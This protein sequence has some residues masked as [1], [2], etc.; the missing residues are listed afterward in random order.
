MG[1]AV[2]PPPAVET[3]TGLSLPCRGSSFQSGDYVHVSWSTTY[4]H[5]S[6]THFSPRRFSQMKRKGFTLIELLVVIAIIGLLVALLL[7][8]LARARES[9][10]SATCQSNLRSFGQGFQLFAERD[11]GKR[12]CSGATISSAMAVPTRLAGSPICRRSAAADGNKMLCPSNELRGLEKL[13]DMIGSATPSS[14]DPGDFVATN[15]TR[16]PYY[17]NS[18]YCNNLV[19]ASKTKTI[20]DNNGSGLTAGTAARI[21]VVSKMVADGFNTNYAQSWFMARSGPK[22][23]TTVPSS[24]LPFTGVRAGQKDQGGAYAG[25]ALR[26]IEK[27]KVVS[28]AIPMLGDA[29]PGDTNEAVLVAAINEEFPAGARLA[30]SFNDGPSFVT[31][32]IN[33]NTLDKI[34]LGTSATNTLSYVLE[35]DVLPLPDEEGLGGVDIN[36]DGINDD[37]VQGGLHGGL[38]G[39]VILQDI[40]DFGTVHGSGSN[41]SCNILFADGSVKTIYDVNGDTFINPGFPMTG[42]TAESDG[43][44]NSRC[45]IGPADMYNGPALNLDEIKKNQFE[46]S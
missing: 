10:R 38:D 22:L 27:S 45:E 12:Y 11:P 29:A 36:G 15:T 46:T 1:S 3:A 44:T 39:N 17:K 6:S 21:K 32:S 25:I 33:I 23:A 7:P 16:A 8:A 43:Y 40:R 34:A 4:F 31:S 20:W 13:N 9:A 37:L 24:G 18:P 5:D 42:G 28:S 14:S 2:R 19:I 41:K 30:E 26:T 35:G